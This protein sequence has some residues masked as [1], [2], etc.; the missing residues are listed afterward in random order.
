MNIKRAFLAAAAVLMVPSLAMAQTTATFLT[1]LDITNDAAASLNVELTCN[2]GNPLVQ[3]F[4]LSDGESVTFSVANLDTDTA[5]CSINLSGLSA[6][7]VEFNDGCTFTGDTLNAE[8]T[9]DLL[10]EPVGTLVEVATSFEGVEDPNIDTSFTTVIECMNVS[11]T[12]GPDFIDV[13]VE[14]TDGSFSAVWYADPD[15]G[16]DCSVT[17]NP[18]SSAVEGDSCDF[19]FMLG[20]TEAGCDV[21]GGVFFEG[22]P[23]LSQYGMAI[24]VLLMLGVGFVGFRRF[25]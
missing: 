16:T 24:M 13:T 20:D 21:V 3:D 14:N 9:C 12:T 7:Y 15:G 10:V 8:N 6:G 18:A 4:D 17:L 11:P 1:S 22:I 23:T 19:S 5:T 25:V 2:S